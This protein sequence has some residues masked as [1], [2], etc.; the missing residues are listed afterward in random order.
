MKILSVI[1]LLY[2]TDIHL[3]AINMIDKKKIFD[4][5]FDRL[6]KCYV[7]AYQGKQPILTVDDNSV[8]SVEPEFLNH[9]PSDVKTSLIVLVRDENGS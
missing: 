6:V 5:K 7:D 3:K 1:L 9:L 2:Q 8:I 4:Q